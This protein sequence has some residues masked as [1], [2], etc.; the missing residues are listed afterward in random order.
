MNLVN[1]PCIRERFCQL[2]VQQRDLTSTS[3]NFLFI[4]RTFRHL[5]V[6]PGD[7]KSTS[8]NFLCIRKTFLKLSELPQDFA[9]TSFNFLRVRGN[10]CQHCA[11]LPDLQ[12]TQSPFR[13]SV[14]LSITFQ[15]G[16]RTF[17][18][19]P[20][21]RVTYRQLCVQS[22]DHPSAFRAS[23]GYSANFPYVYSTFREL[24]STFR[25]FEGPSIN[26]HAS[27]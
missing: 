9:A 21:S 15:C 3:V 5:F 2:F 8:M 27:A 1:F 14:G 17:C 26:F 18:N 11:R 25:A 12:S 22:W 23:V 6:D 10:I 16:L 20:C 24:P 13:A 4:L 19:F 7:I